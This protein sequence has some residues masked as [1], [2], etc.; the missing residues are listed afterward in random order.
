ML[1]FNV[2]AMSCG[3][4][5]GAVTKVVKEVDPQAKVEVDLDSKKVTVESPQARNAFAEA[6]TEAGYPPAA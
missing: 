4:C 6:L 2:P 3:H 1:E 5:V